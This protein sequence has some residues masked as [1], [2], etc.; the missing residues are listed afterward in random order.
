MEN[1]EHEEDDS[2]EE[3]MHASAQRHPFAKLVAVVGFAA[4]A[5]LALKGFES[6]VIQA[7]VWFGLAVVAMLAGIVALLWGILDEVSDSRA[8][9]ITTRWRIEGVADILLED[10]DQANELP[11]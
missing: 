8:E 7:G 10:E 9:L 5:L 3:M 4:A 11:D 2:S 6:P 1:K